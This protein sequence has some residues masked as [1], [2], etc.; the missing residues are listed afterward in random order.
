[1]SYKQKT[2]ANR[3]ALFGGGPPAAGGGRSNKPRPANAN[4][5]KQS[6][7]GDRNAL[8]GN[9][10][11]ANSGDSKP[12]PASRPTSNRP[13]PAPPASAHAATTTTSTSTPPTPTHTSYNFQSKTS[14]RTVTTV[15][16]GQAKIAKMKE[17]EEFRSK[18][19]KA[20][21]KTMFS[22]PDPISAGTYYKRAA[23]AYKICGENRLERLHRI[24]SGDMQMRQDSYAVAASEY[25][26]AAELS[27]MSDES[28][29]RKQKEV[30]QLF[31]NAA[32][33]WAAMGETGKMAECYTKAAFGLAI[34]KPDTDY[35]D[36]KTHEA[37]EESI[38][39]YVPDVLNRHACHRMTGNKKEDLRGKT[40]KGL[41][42]GV[43]KISAAEE[44]ERAREQ[45][46]KGAY[47][48]EDVQQIMTSF[49][50]TGEFQSALYAAGAI[51]AI[52][53]ESGFSTISLSRAYVTETI[54]QL[55]CKRN[56]C[57]ISPSLVFVARPHADNS[58]SLQS[59]VN[60]ATSNSCLCMSC[61]P[62]H[63]LT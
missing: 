50:Q 37:L 60:I 1:M 11:A 9:A 56:I 29:L 20:M 42:K 62:V 7:A 25:T 17:A 45:M 14:R 51:T 53:E 26:R 46:A 54:L 8:F 27:S 3:D 13:T 39:I 40:N 41:G 63:P 55:V 43:I 5:Y 18:A 10:S 24:A 22:R 33:A 23:E 36:K 2:D 6:A 21:E 30:Y 49:S 58:V 52:L 61:I 16:T 32:D 57:S 12:R 59:H 4:S 35:F 28:T 15:L 19:K 38:E 34:D 31:K 44:K 48:H 47:T